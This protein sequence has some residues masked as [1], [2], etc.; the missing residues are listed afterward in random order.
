MWF[1]NGLAGTPTS[2]MRWMVLYK[3]KYVRF[4]EHIATSSISSDASQ[5]IHS[6]CAHAILRKCV[7][8][9]EEKPSGGPDKSKIPDVCRAYSVECIRVL[10]MFRREGLRL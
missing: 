9:T 7:V 5:A 6:L 1:A 4:C 10:D 8:V 3:R 2:S